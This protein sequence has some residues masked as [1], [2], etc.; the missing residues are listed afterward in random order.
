MLMHR[1]R[2]ISNCLSPCT[3]CAA[4]VAMVELLVEAARAQTEGV[5][6]AA[7]IMPT[8]VPGLPD[9]I[10]R[11]KPL[12]AGDAADASVADLE[13]L[14]PGEELKAAQAAAVMQELLKMPAL[15]CMVR[16]GEFPA[17]HLFM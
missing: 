12:P 6:A 13:G 9:F 1:A 5:A 15:S 11:R 2:P 8:S 14:L 4:A 16:G 3:H 10:T 17:A 7:S